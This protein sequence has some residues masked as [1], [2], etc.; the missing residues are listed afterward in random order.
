MSGSRRFANLI[1]A[2]KYEDAL[3]VARQQVEDGAQVI[4]INFDEGMLDA[5]FAMQKFLCLIA[6]EP[7]IAKVPI[8]ID[9]SNFSVIETGL[10]WVQGKPIV[11]SISLKGKS[12]ALLYFVLPCAG[13]LVLFTLIL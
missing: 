7:E 8:M 1:K 9:S 11:N 10:K 3:A 2:N 13:L 12:S 6:S 4:D 5:H